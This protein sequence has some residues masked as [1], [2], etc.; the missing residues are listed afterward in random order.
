MTAIRPIAVAS[1]ATPVS[2][3]RHC[4]A[5]PEA[6]A[7]ARRRPK[8]AA[9]PDFPGDVSVAVVAHNAAE[10]LPDTLQSLRDAGCP[11]ARITVIDVASTDGTAAY[12]AREAP[13]LHYRRLDANLGPSPGRN[14]GIRECPTRWVLLMD[15][16]VMI[17]SDTVYLLRRAAEAPGVAIA[18]PVVVH[19]DRPE[20]IQYADT[21]FHFICEAINPYLDRPVAT[22][23]N[24][25]RDIGAA[26][27]C[28]LL[29]ACAVAKEV[30]L[31]DER[32]FIGKED[33]DFTHRVKLA[34]YRILEPPLARVR[35]RSRS[36]GP[37][38][39][40]HQIR[41]RWHIIL[42]NYEV[43]TIL[44]LLPVLLLHEVLQAI[45]LTV[46]GHAVI[47][48]RAWVGL[49]RLLPALADDR[50]RV[51]RIRARSDREL[52]KDGALVVRGDLAGGRFARWA[53]RKYEL[54][55]RAYWRAICPA[56]S[57]GNRSAPAP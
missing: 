35:H 37:W 47:Y 19:A 24:D 30:G 6:R 54:I 2:G 52:L 8:S 3:R 9:A 45:V 23:G 15:A 39:F 44:G 38:L 14:V 1:L 27:G 16:D 33:G 20:V 50:N 22:R 4:Q 42:K 10:T 13:D 46:K 41:N 43:R 51:N 32:Y 56:L 36:R 48:V 25:T 40:Y 21:G 53:R 55:L 26:S 7:D 49:C 11:E 18:S 5:V 28:A 34:G 31:F 29:I 12:L 57:I 17:E